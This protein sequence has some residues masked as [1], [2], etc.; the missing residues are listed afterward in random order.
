[1]KKKTKEKLILMGK[2]KDKSKIGMKLK[3]QVTTE[4]KS[5]PIQFFYSILDSLL[6][7]SYLDILGYQYQ[8]PSKPHL[9][10]NSRP[11]KPIRHDVSIANQNDCY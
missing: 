10:Y 4:R 6:A 2:I 3:A 11:I 9:K 8:K 5:L 1:M 7:Y